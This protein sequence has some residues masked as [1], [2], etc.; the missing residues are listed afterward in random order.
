[1]LGTR[2]VVPVRNTI[3]LV[4]I[5][6]IVIDFGM[7][8]LRWIILLE[9]R[10]TNF[11]LP[12]PCLPISFCLDCIQSHLIRILPIVPITIRGFRLGVPA[13]SRPS[14]DTTSPKPIEAT[15]EE[16]KY[17]CCQSK[18]SGISEG[19]RPS[20]HCVEPGL[21]NKKKCNVKYKSDESNCCGETRNATAETAH[22]H[23]ADV[24]EESEDCSDGCKAEGYEMQHESVSQ[25][26]YCHFGD[27]DRQIIANEFVD[28][29][30]NCFEPLVRART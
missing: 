18:P 30:K 6:L 12:L 2:S 5:H 14:F 15:A 24:R 16:E 4:D 13:G 29:W 11:S 7:Q 22:G 9:S 3:V 20:L 26:F 8:W 23:L 10:Q 19:G 25:P 17:P 28:V 27:F 1:M 21:G